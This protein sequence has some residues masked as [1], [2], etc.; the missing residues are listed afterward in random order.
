MVNLAAPRGTIIHQ[1]ENKQR[2]ININVGGEKH[3]PY[4]S[5][6][7]NFPESPLA[8]IIQDENRALL[9][10]DAEEDMYFFDRH[11]GIFTE[12]LNYYQ[13][14]KL[15]CP[16]DVCGPMFQEEL[17]FWGIDETQM[18]GILLVKLV[19]FDINLILILKLFP[20]NIEK[21]GLCR[22]QPCNKEVYSLCDFANHWEITRIFRIQ[23]LIT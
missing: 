21:G 22:Y 17:N 12:I 13:T 11:P 5:T 9:D 20:P 16:R 14:G 4:I 18:E 10:H 8:W 2:K 7:K 3:S 1:T 6:L 15:H 23:R 19:Q